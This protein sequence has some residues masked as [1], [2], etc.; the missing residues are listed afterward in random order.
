[1][2]KGIKRDHMRDI[3]ATHYSSEKS[4][5][6]RS[7][8]IG[9][10]NDM[11]AAA[12]GL[13]CGLSVATFYNSCADVRHNQP[14]HKGRVSTLNKLESEDRTHLDAHIRELRS[15]MEGDKAVERS[16]ESGIRGSGQALFVG[17]TMFSQGVQ[18]HF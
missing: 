4:S 16:P 1:M 12:Y 2:A 10:R 15:S 14:Y 7:F 8:V 5:F 18:K 3:L 9:E 17:T 13:A 6:S 11:C